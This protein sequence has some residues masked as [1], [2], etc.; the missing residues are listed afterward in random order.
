MISFLSDFRFVP[1]VFEPGRFPVNPSYEETTIFYLL[2]IGSIV[3]AIVFA[4]SPPYSQNIFK[5]S[6]T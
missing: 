2:C 5:N 1:Y 4:P 6:K 3:S